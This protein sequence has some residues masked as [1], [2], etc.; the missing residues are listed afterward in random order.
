MKRVSD[1]RSK[2]QSKRSKLVKT[3]LQDRPYCE[4]GLIIAKRNPEN[5]CQRWS[6][7][8]H[9]P[10]TRA[11]GGDILDPKNTISIC[12]TCHEWIHYNPRAATEEGLLIHSW[13]SNADL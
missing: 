11:R 13:D 2:T 6:T 10:L 3:E 1:K 4:A 5:E 12:R 7:E 9:E 8:L